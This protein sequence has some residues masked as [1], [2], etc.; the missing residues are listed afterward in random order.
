MGDRLYKDETGKIIRA[1]VF[2]DAETNVLTGGTNLKIAFER[3]LDGSEVE[4]TATI[5]VTSPVDKFLEFTVAAGD[6]NQAGVY[7][8]HSLHD[9]GSNTFRGNKT[10]LEVFEKFKGPSESN[11]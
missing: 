8:F 1:R 11:E 6:L 10:T 5:P 7:I 2:T 3:P 9:Q 4:K